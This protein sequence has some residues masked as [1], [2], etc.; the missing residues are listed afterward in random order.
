MSHTDEVGWRGGN[1]FPSLVYSKKLQYL[2]ASII[3]EAN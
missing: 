1:Y 2:V 3:I